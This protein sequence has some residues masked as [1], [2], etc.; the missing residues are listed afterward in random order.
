MVFSLMLSGGA[1]MSRTDILHNPDVPPAAA[2]DTV[3][4]T[5]KTHRL[6]D[7]YR[8]ERLRKT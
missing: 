6:G 8:A 3:V 7:I 4:D 2:I 5:L 1:L